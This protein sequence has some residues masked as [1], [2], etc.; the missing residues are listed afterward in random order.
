MTAKI[1]QSYPSCI[2]PRAGRCSTSAAAM[3]GLSSVVRDQ[4]PSSFR[5]IIVGDMEKKMETMMLIY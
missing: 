2:P 1:I 4:S 5:G 3:S